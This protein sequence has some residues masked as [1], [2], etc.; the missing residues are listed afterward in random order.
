MSSTL[1]AL[2]ILGLNTIKRCGFPQEVLGKDVFNEE[3]KE[4][5]AEVKPIQNLIDILTQ[6][7]HSLPKFSL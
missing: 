2:H 5:V 6:T 7:S 3:V 1:C 4:A